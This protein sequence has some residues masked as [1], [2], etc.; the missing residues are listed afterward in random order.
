LDGLPRLD[1]PSIERTPVASP[2]WIEEVAQRPSQ[3]L[4]PDA[5]AELTRA[6]GERIL[7]IDGAMGTMIQ[8]Y[9]LD[10]VQYRGE[11]FASYDGDLKG[12]ND[13]LSLTQ[14]ALIREIHTAYLAAGADLI[15]TNTFNG[16]RIS[17]ADY[18]LQDICYELNVA[19]ARLAREAVDDFNDTERP[20]YV[21]G[22]LGPTSKTASISPDVND[23]GARN[24]SYDQLVTAYLEEANGLVDGGADILLI[25]TIVDTLNA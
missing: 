6:L 4:R 13:L 3:N 20:R 7:V 22:S 25:E 17:Q 23:P 2:T 16:T 5:T 9:Q 18:G 15:C 10:E 21:V 24:V 8:G 12:N 19:A 1:L 11:R 14:P